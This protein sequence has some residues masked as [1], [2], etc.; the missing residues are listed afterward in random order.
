MPPTLAQL[1]RVEVDVVLYAV[2]Q[3][4]QQT[5]SGGIQ[6]GLQQNFQRL[7]FLRAQRIIGRAYN[8]QTIAFGP[9]AQILGG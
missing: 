9:F 8:H 1:H 4:H 3:N 5:R 7:F 6:P 2:G